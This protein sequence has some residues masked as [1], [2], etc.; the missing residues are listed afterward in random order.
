MSLRALVKQD[1]ELTL[2]DPGEWG[3]QFIAF[4][5]DQR[6]DKNYRDA[7]LPV[8]EQRP[9]AGQVQYHSFSEEMESGITAVTP[10]PV[11][12]VSFDSID[13]DRMGY[14]RKGWVVIIP[15]KED[16]AGAPSVKYSVTR[17]FDVPEVNTVR[18]YLREVNGS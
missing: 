7:A 17:H 14:P 8:D 6:Q 11:L 18:L 15:P 3:V 4:S 12:S 2:E 10:F 5:G 13:L 16:P 9:L 1:T